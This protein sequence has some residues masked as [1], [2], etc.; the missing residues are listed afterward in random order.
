MALHPSQDGLIAEPGK[1][2]PWAHCF[3]LSHKVRLPLLALDS[4]DAYA[5]GEHAPATGLQ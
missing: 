2:V 5:V 3:A 1:A 4:T